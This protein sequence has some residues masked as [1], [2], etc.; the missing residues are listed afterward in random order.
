MHV[1]FA[2]N[3]LSTLRQRD[4]KSENENKQLSI[5]KMF[6]DH[7]PQ[8]KDV[9]VECVKCNSFVFMSYKRINTTA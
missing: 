7:A 1:N 9:E 2:I 8:N 4:I 5:L 3:D 6:K